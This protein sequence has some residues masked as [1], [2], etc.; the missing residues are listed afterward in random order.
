MP[1]VVGRAVNAVID[2][3]AVVLLMMLLVLTVCCN[4]GE[5]RLSKPD[6]LLLRQMEQRSA[7]RVS[8][9]T[10][11]NPF[12]SSFATGQLMPGQANN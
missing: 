7:V 10:L 9:A 1:T 8:R 3:C 5:R 2:V 11:Q 4:H 6:E 12:R